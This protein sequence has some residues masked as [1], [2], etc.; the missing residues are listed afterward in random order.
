M[1]SKLGV[2]EA[3]L[4]RA[5]EKQM[6]NWELTRSQ[7]L[8]EPEPET[9]SEVAEFLCL[10]RMAGIDSRK[11]TAALAERLGW[12]VFGRELLEMMA[13]DDHRRRQIYASMDERDLGWLE[14]V[15]DAVVS[16][17]FERND[18]FRRLCET[19]LSLARQGNAIFVGRGADLILPKA[20]GLRVRLMASLES[21]LGHF[22]REQDLGHDEAAKALEK[23]E[24]GR[25]DFLR[26]HFRVRADDPERFDLAINLDRFTVDRA[27]EL[28]L[29]AQKLREG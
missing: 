26:R 2:S 4:S 24:N 13:G 20:R 11:L 12:P 18:Y 14:E 27:V 17:E 15:L 7:Q 1:S 22:T 10:S 25:E 21:R 5:V 8:E 3:T 19:V 9:K 29:E 16:R 28:I 23:I 6:R